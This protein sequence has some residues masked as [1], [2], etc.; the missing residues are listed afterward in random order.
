VWLGF[1]LKCSIEGHWDSEDMRFALRPKV[2]RVQSGSA[3]ERAGLKKGDVLTHVNGIPLDTVEG[4]KQF[5]DLRPGDRF[6][7][8]IRRGN[9]SRTLTMTATP[10]PHYARLA[11]RERAVRDS[12]PPGPDD[13]RYIGALGPTAIEVRGLSHVDVIVDEERGEV[14]IRMPDATVRLWTT[15]DSRE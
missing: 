1:G 5:T 11:E 14:L 2:F 8:S 6:G 10:I 7:L 4:T 12:V 13:L 9:K 3:A 15:D